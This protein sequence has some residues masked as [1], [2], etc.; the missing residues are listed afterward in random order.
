M[1]P[2]QANLVFR[3]VMTLA[4]AGLLL[5]PGS[6]SAQQPYYQGKSLNLLVD[7]SAGGPTD[8]ECRIYGT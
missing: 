8:I 4:F 2:S 5:C 7:F 3:S 6:A 1:K